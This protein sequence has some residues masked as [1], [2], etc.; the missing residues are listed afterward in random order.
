[1]DKEGKKGHNN[2]KRIVPSGQRKKRTI[3]IRDTLQTVIG[4]IEQ[5]VDSIAQTQPF[6]TVTETPPL[7]DEISGLRA[8]LPKKTGKKS[9]LG[10]SKSYEP[11]A[12]DAARLAELTAMK[13]QGL[14]DIY[15]TLTGQPLGQKYIS[16]ARHKQELINLIICVENQRRQYQPMVQQQ[17]EIKQDIPVED[18][19]L[20]QGQGQEQ[21]QEQRPEHPEQPEQP[22]QIIPGPTYQENIIPPLDQLTVPNYTRQ[23]RDEIAAVPEINVELSEKDTQL[24]DKLG[25]PILDIDSPEYNEQLLN[26]EQIENEHAEMDDSFDFLYP[27]LNDPN[28]NVKIAQRKEFNDTKYDGKIRSIK[29]HANLLCKADFELLPHQLF[30]KNFLSAQTP[31]N[32]LLLYHGLGTGKTCSAIGIAEEMRTYIKQVGLQQQTGDASGQRILV[33]ASPNVQQNF[34]LQLFDERKL[35]T[36][37]EHWNLDTCV[38]ANLLKDINPTNMGGLSKDMVIKQINAVINQYYVFLGYFEFANY[39]KRKTIISAEITD[40]EVKK[41]IRIKKLKAIFNNRLII[42]DEVHNIRIADD[43]KKNQRTANLLM[44]VVKYSENMRL[45]LLSAT[46]MYN[47]YKEIIWLTNLLNMVDKRGT[48]KESD[49]F[50]TN[51]NFTKART[52]KDGRKYEGGKELLKRKL[53]GYISYVRGENP[54]TFPYRIYPEVFA[55]DNAIANFEYPKTQL[56]G[57]EIE[58]PMKY[59]PVYLSEIGEYQ[60]KGYDFIIKKIKEE[61]GEL[62][63][64]DMETFG[65]IRLQRPLE[66][67]DMVY[68]SEEFDN[69]SG[70]LGESSPT[71]DVI[72]DIVGKNGLARCLSFKTMQSPYFLRHEFEY[73][74]EILSRYGRSFS[75]DEIPKYSNK[76]SSICNSIMA[77]RGIVIVFSQYVD[78]GVVPLAL[79]LEELG[80]TRTGAAK[81]TKPLFKTA[82]APPIGALTLKPKEDGDTSFKQAKYIMITGDPTFSPDNLAD[83]KLVTNQNNKNGEIVKVILITKAAAEGLDFKNIR[84]VHIMDPWY[85][86]NRIEQII[87]RGVR[88]LSHCQLP[89][90]DRNVEIYLH[91]TKPRTNTGT[92]PSQ[93]LFVG[94]EVEGEV[95]NPNEPVSEAP[96]SEEQQQFTEAPISEE[97]QQ[98]TEAPI[99]EEQQQF[100]EAPTS[101][102]K[103]STEEPASEEGQ[104]S[105]EE[106]V[107]EAPASEEEQQFTEAPISEEQQQF[108]EESVSEAPVSEE[109]AS[110]EEQQS[111][112][113]PVSEAPVSE[114]EQQQ[115]TEAPASESS[116]QEEQSTQEPADLYVYRYAE[117]KAMQ[118]GK[119]TRLLKEIAVD[120][121]LNIEQTN[122][123]VD[124]LLAIPANQNIKLNLSTNNQQIDFKIGDKP[125]SDICDYMDNCNFTCSP[126]AVVNEDTIDKSTYTEEFVK[127][128]YSMIVKRI[129]DLF[130][131]QTMYKRENLIAGINQVKIYPVE[132]IDYVLTRFI[133]NNNEYITD[134]YG[135][136]GR[137]IN[138]DKYY[139][140]QPI[141]ITDEHI[142]LYERSVPVDFKPDKLELELPKKQR[143]PVYQLEEE[144]LS[145]E[146]VQ[147]QLELG[148]LE[149]LPK[150]NVLGLEDKYNEILETM[151]TNLENALLRDDII[152]ESGETDWYKHMGNVFQTV[153]RNHGIS[154]ETLTKYII[155]HNLDTLLFEE[156]MVLVKVI[157]SRSG[158]GLLN[159]LEQTIKQ[160]FDKK[161]VKGSDGSKGIIIVKDFHEDLRQKWKIFAQ[162]PENLVSW[163]EI[164]ETDYSIYIIAENMRK[165]IIKQPNKHNPVIGFM[166]L[167]KN[168]DTVFKT[169]NLPGKWGNKGSACNV[170]GK[171]DILARL[172]S[173]LEFPIYNNESI[174]QYYT[175]IITKKGLQVE[176][177]LENGIY[178]K[179]LCVILEI[180]LRY[181]QETSYKGKIWFY[182]LEEADINEIVELKEL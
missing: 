59:I 163:K 166:H 53:T 150:Q 92:P 34:R 5:T 100:T 123:T 161:M 64:D 105:T 155:Y 146:Q 164:D 77:S 78:G 36:D 180:L 140:F 30:V 174:R 128:N 137:L 26:N 85:N 19:V 57:Q 118:I 151:K 81:Q 75:K 99:S 50:D 177:R 111:T 115:S 82:P 97:Q 47:S 29:E 28:F 51:G 15:A 167:F 158:E 154:E 24:Q 108:I 33:V 142:S 73:K 152:I 84:Q 110:E 117:T 179:G 109:P 182:D 172:N 67:L 96:S 173:I 114:E 148:E 74:P 88:N 91:A 171:K 27:E 133:N 37:G 159:Q 86:M 45:L 68:P 42:I 87:G 23:S 46:P 66:A 113:E 58:D 134:K 79:C 141:E 107:S 9:V 145:E 31:Y 168:G 98:F 11:T 131:E 14:R 72:R 17:P 102:N 144:P 121:I 143:E 3:R 165:F 122:F 1:M 56:N 52:G 119:L 38:G 55:P 2:T 106:S 6:D 147:R 43:N 170:L 103:Q 35:K 44:D 157:Y 139:V 153:V 83:M 10:C 149:E 181:F 125:Y 65:F 71:Q 94:G 16:T 162:D 22:N 176:K 8:L 7:A 126:S 124:K 18:S 95:K 89:F 69:G 160:Y 40:E 90:E 49:V 54:Y 32:A 135:R 76:I 12:N 39:I 93:G 169:K 61:S 132:Q 175:T 13:G 120:C 129:R 41:Q 21:E 136:S 4:D 62:S 63:D 116:T 178:A 20:G 156:R 48:I 60:K 25:D 80:F 130:K 138:K 104:Q 112:E 70:F 127:M 101:Q